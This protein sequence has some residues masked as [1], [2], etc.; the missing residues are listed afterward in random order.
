[1]YYAPFTYGWT[2]G[3]SAWDHRFWVLHPHL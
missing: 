1:V 2:I 3:A